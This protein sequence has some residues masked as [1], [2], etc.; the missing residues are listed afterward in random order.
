[1]TTSRRSLPRHPPQRAAALHRTLQ[2]RGEAVRIGVVYDLSG[3]FAAPAVLSPA[4][5]APRS[6][7]ISSTS[8]AALPASTRSC[9]SMPIAE[10]GRRGDQR[11]RAP[12]RRGRSRSSTASMPARKAVPL[13]AKVEAQRKISGSRRRSPRRCS[14][15][16]T[17]NTSSAR[18]FIS[19]QYGE[20][21][22]P[23]SPVNAKA[24]QARRAKRRQGRDHPRGWAYGVG[25]ADAGNLFAKGA[26]CKSS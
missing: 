18:R 20:L 2:R 17:C 25:V 15:T 26:A 12:D 23:L 7:S 24:K 16:R 5:S 6:R 8:A 3:P 13:A 4:P 10:Q 14:R 11:G 19:D 1:M 21:L 22:R 9:R